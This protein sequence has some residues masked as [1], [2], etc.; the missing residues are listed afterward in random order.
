MQR[1]WW[2]VIAVVF[3]V[4]VGGG[5]ALW[6]L[7]GRPLYQPGQVRDG[8]QLTAPLEPPAQDD[9]VTWIV[10]DDVRLAHAAVGDGPRVVVVHGGPSI[11][12]DELP[13]GLAKLGDRFTVI[14]YDQRGCGGSSRPFDR[15]D[16]GFL[17]NLQSLERTLGLGAQIADLE[18]IRR[19]LGEE[20]LVLLGHSFG[21]LL[22][23]L[24][25]VEFPERVR[26][27]VL[28]APADLVVLPPPSGG[29]FE[30]VR[31][32]LPEPERGAYDEFVAEYLDFSGV[33]AES[34]RSLAERHVRFGE[35]FAAASGDP[36]PP[37]AV[38]RVGGFAPYAMYFGMGR[39]HDWS[40]AVRAVDVPTLLVHGD[41]D[42]VPVEASR[43]YAA[44]LDGARLEVIEGAGHFPFADRP[45]AFEAVIAPF[46]AEVTAE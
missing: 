27:L 38:D 41:R 40:D 7:M 3:V 5:W 10:E 18:R 13:A 34:E 2:V 11:P 32:R 23:T 39:A 35:F 44:L 31:A 22:A 25:A 17:E 9:G 1:K 6:S 15:F 21:G 16:G 36:F 20:R 30:Q 37:L 8:A 26:A 4:L 14:S 19:R 33:F 46:L 43:R 45:D 12:F 28:V 42:L 29:L 24:Y